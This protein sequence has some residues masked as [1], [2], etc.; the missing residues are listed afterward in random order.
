[1]GMLVEASDAPADEA[2]AHYE[3]LHSPSET[4]ERRL[5]RRV[6]WQWPDPAN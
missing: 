6:Q 5:V 4:A 3:D 1:M 2:P